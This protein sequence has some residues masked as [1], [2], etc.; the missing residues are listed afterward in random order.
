MSENRNLNLIYFRTLKHRECSH[1]K[2]PFSNANVPYP[3]ERHTTPVSYAISVPLEAW[4]EGGA[5]QC[6][7]ITQKRLGLHNNTNLVAVHYTKASLPRECTYIQLYA[8]TY[9]YT[10]YIHMIIN[11]YPCILGTGGYCKFIT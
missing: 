11:I 6:K 9:T 7:K 4:G 5:S 10:T 2:V 8:Y 3:Y 1:S